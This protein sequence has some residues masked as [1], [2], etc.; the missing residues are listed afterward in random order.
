MLAET[1]C[2]GSRGEGSVL[3]DRGDASGA[4]AAQLAGVQAL[5]ITAVTMPRIVA[6]FPQIG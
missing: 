4:P 3:Q 2:R 5:R 6:P 1:G